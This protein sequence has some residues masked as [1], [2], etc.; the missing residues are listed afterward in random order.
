MQFCW[1]TTELSTAFLDFT[2]TCQPCLLASIKY[3]YVYKF[4]VLVE[5]HKVVVDVCAPWQ[6]KHLF[7]QKTI[8][9]C[10]PFAPATAARGSLGAHVQLTARE[11]GRAQ[12][13]G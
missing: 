12:K 5:V 11:L 10:P 2:P 6:Y 8:I 13:G 4:R 9:P 1:Q 7:S 3:M